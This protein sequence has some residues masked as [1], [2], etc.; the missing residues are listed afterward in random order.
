MDEKTEDGRK[1]L[2]E[3]STERGLSLALAFPFPLGL[4]LMMPVVAGKQGAGAAKTE[5][6]QLPFLRRMVKGSPKPR[7]LCF[8]TAPLKTPRAY[9][10]QHC[11]AASLNGMQQLTSDFGFSKRTW[12]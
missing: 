11:N 12:L 8:F 4:S 6:A 2:R 9:G 1:G 7:M 5:P 10:I 3:D